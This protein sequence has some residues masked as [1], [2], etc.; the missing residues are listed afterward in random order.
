MGRRVRAT[1][2]GALAVGAGL[3]AVAVAVPFLLSTYWTFVPAAGVPTSL[4]ADI[5]GR[6]AQT[7]AMVALLVLLPARDLRAGPTPT[8][9]A[10]PSAARRPA[11]PR[12]D[13]WSPR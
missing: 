11:R 8:G 13:G 2:R 1:T 3:F 6:S 12:P 10:G 7:C 5:V 4:P 9:R